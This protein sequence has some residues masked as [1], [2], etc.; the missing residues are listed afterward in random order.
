[1]A[2]AADALRIHATIKLVKNCSAISGGSLICG[3]T[4]SNVSNSQPQRQRHQWHMLD[5][6]TNSDHQ[7]LVNSRPHCKQCSKDLADGAMAVFLAAFVLFDFM[8]GQRS[9]TIDLGQIGS[10]FSTGHLHPTSGSTEALAE[11]DSSA[12]VFNV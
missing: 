1:M 11:S 9:R 7:G 12:V 8:A 4:S 10:I 3:G 6:V 2:I 5:G